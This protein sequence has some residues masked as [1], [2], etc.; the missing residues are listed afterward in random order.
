MVRATLDDDDVLDP[1][2]YIYLGDAG[3]QSARCRL[4]LAGRPRRDPVVV[5]A[6]R[7]Q[8]HRGDRLGRPLAHD[9]G[10]LPLPDATAS[11]LAW[12]FRESWPSRFTGATLTAGLLAS[13]ESDRPIGRFVAPLHLV[14]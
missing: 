7:R 14:V 11:E 12:L 6:D 2:N 3:H 10:G 8:R 1:L 5:G 9:R 13:G 4:R